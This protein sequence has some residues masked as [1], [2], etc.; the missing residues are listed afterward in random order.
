MKTEYWILL[1]LLVYWFF[2]RKKDQDN[3]MNLPGQSPGAP[4]PANN[5][6]FVGGGGT[7]G[8]GGASGG[9]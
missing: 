2:I 7:F 3:M 8:G 5:G 9:W 1:A 4:Q 6:T